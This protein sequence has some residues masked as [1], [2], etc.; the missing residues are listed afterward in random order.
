MRRAGWRVEIAPEIAG[1]YEEAPPTLVEFAK[2]DRRWCRGNIQHL[3]ILVAPGLHWV[4][5]MHILIGVMAY[6][7]SPLW[8]AFLLIGAAIGVESGPATADDAVHN[9]SA[10]VGVTLLTSLLLF[11]PKLLGVAHVLLR[12]DLRESYGGARRVVSGALT[13]TAL[14][15]LLAPVL[16]MAHSRIVY[17]VL[18]GKGGGWSAQTREADGLSFAEAARWGGWQA[19]AALAFAVACV[20]HPHVAAAAWPILASLVLAAP[21]ASA[22]AHVDAGSAARSLGLL[23]TPEEIAP[24]DVVRRAGVAVA[25]TPFDALPAAL[26]Q[27]APDQSG[28]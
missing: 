10:I 9:L 19:T 8:L 6:A 27:A 26:P 22:T 25:E 7:S 17:E 4:S 15:A 18:A 21:L 11:G 23:V 14:S 28:A 3:P 13:E 12:P 5:R 2:R 1:S 20:F 24:P 16:M